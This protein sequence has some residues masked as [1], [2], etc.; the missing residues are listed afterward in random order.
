[1]SW[2][3]QLLAECL[4]D[5][6]AL[7]KGD[8]ETI[9]KYSKRTVRVTQKHNEECKRLLAL[10]GIP[11]IEVKDT[12]SSPYTNPRSSKNKLKRDWTC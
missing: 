12:Y 1:M 6:S 3:S 4:P 11:I 9:E 2:C 8:Q 10:M 7:Q 5:V